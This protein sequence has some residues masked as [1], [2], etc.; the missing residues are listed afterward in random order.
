MFNLEIPSDDQVV[1]A[2]EALNGSA[3]ALELRDR[4]MRDGHRQSRCELAIQRARVRGRIW[5]AHD[6]R[7]VL[8][9][10]DDRNAVLERE[11]ADLLSAYDTARGSEGHTIAALQLGCF[12]ATNRAAFAVKST[13]PTAPADMRGL[14]SALSDI[15][16]DF[17]QTGN[18]WK[19]N[20]CREAASALSRTPAVTDEAVER[21]WTALKERCCADPYK[22]KRCVMVE[23]DDLAAALATLSHP[24]PGE[25]E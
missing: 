16:D 23:R 2:L 11:F 15:A 12:M 7:I 14:V 6:L 19:A 17:D 24:V 4:L 8:P 18:H 3:T 25:Q 22:A 21:V 10:P 13:P 5:I 1:E 20:R 9:M